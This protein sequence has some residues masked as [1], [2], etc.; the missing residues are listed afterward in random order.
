MSFVD[1]L[2]KTMCAFQFRLYHTLLQLFHISKDHYEM[3]FLNQSCSLLNDH[4]DAWHGHMTYHN[5][6]FHCTHN[7]EQGVT[8]CYN[9]DCGHFNECVVDLTI[10][11]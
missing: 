7:E 1:N 4:K 11:L 8:P 9:I 2:F 3:E 10:L 6:I 5:V